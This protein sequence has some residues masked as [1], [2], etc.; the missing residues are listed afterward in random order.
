MSQRGVTCT[1]GE[2]LR[3]AIEQQAYDLAVNVCVAPSTVYRT[4]RCFVAGNLEAD[5]AEPPRSGAARKLSAR[6]QAL[7]VATAQR[8]RQ[9]CGVWE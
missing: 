2:P 3:A 5:P 9:A 7:L 8:T 1:F 6:Q 4:N